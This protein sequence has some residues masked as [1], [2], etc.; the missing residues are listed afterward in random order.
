MKEILMVAG[1]ELI[2]NLR[3]PGFIIMTLLIPA[4]GALALLAGSI[5]VTALA[6]CDSRS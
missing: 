1:Q 2:V 4:L 5:S 6:G 3:R